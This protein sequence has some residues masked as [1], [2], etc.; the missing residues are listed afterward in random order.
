MT[1]SSNKVIEAMFR[2]G[3]SS[4]DTL[5]L[6]TL[7]K[8]MIEL[9]VAQLCRTK[10]D[11]IKRM[12]NLSSITIN[13]HQFH[14][15]QMLIKDLKMKHWILLRLCRLW[16]NADGKPCWPPLNITITDLDPLARGSKLSFPN[17]CVPIYCTPRVLHHIS[18]TSGPKLYYVSLVFV[19]LTEC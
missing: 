6:A 7:L 15:P 11:I 12:P 17:A 10:L 9:Y 13:Y 19:H 16:G 4:L 2:E 5:A 3:R 14:V 18:A 8:L 1:A